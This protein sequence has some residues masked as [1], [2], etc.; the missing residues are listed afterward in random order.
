M[1]V[2]AWYAGRARYETPKTALEN[3]GSGLAALGLSLLALA[4]LTGTRSPGT[5]RR[6]R[7]PRRMATYLAVL[8]ATWLAGVPAVWAALVYKHARHDFPWFADTLVIPMFES[9]TAVA[10]LLPVWNL[11]WVYA[12]RRYPTGPLDLGAGPLGRRLGWGLVF[13]AAFVVDASLLV[14]AM[15]DGWFP[16]VPLCVTWG[17]LLASLYGLVVRGKHVQALQ[18]TPSVV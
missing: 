9:A 16:V 2:G 13:G 12:T 11:V 15:R 10:V 8:N 14:G 6:P 18:P 17:Y 3:W 5:L 7:I 1:E 4:R